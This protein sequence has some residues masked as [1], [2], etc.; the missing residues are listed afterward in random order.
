MH[1]SGR[2][3]NKFWATYGSLTS[4]NIL[5]LQACKCL[6]TSFTAAVPPQHTSR[7]QICTLVWPSAPGTHTILWKSEIAPSMVNQTATN[8]LRCLLWNF[9]ITS[10]PLFNRYAIPHGVTLW[11]CES[12]F[13][14]VN[15][16]CNGWEILLAQSPAWSPSRPR[17]AAQI[18]KLIHN[19]PGYCMHPDWLH[20]LSDQRF[21]PYKLL[22]H[23]DTTAL[24]G[25]LLSALFEIKVAVKFT[26]FH[27]AC[28]HKHSSYSDVSA[29]SLLFL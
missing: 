27:Q 8:W 26:A 5:P 3:C 10:A 15:T 2:L 6:K 19:V 28:V 12:G 1:P 11:M 17:E 13:Q 14:Y 21:P 29:S 9:K 23:D 24:S 4:T 7:V 25:A 16:K 20:M 22:A 18:S